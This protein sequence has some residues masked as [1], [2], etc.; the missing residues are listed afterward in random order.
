MGTRSGIPTCALRTTAPWLCDLKQAGQGRAPKPR[1]AD[2]AGL[3]AGDAGSGACRAGLDP[4][5][6]ATLAQP[7]FYIPNS[8]SARSCPRVPQIPPHLGTPDPE[9]SSLW[10]THILWGMGL[11]GRRRGEEEGTGAGHTE[12]WWQ[13]MLTATNRAE[14][15]AWGRLCAESRR[16]RFLLAVHRAFLDERAQCYLDFH[17]AFQ[18]D[19]TTI[20]AGTLLSLS[21]LSPFFLAGE[22]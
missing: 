5:A 16:T 21:S 1:T 2:L 11:P 19:G 3:R 10:E 17:V 20:L 8:G 18:S 12:R 6:W 4:E 22:T 13:T 7:C 9:R 14:A 15:G